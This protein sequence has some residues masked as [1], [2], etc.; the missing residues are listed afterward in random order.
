MRIQNN[1]LREGALLTLVDEEGRKG[2]GEIA[3]LPYRS[4]ETLEE[5]INQGR[6]LNV[7][8]TEWTKENWLEKLSSLSLLPSLS[9][10][11]ESA[12]LSIL[13]PIDEKKILSSAFFMGTKED[14]LMQ[15]QKAKKKGFSFAKLKVSTLSMQESLDII[16]ILRGDFRLRIDVNRSWQTKEC[17]DFFSHFPND[18][19]DYVEEPFA[20]PEDLPLFSHP[21]AIDESLEENRLSL[22]DLENIPMLKALVYKPTIQ[23]GISEALPLYTW[24]KQ[25]DLQFILGSS[26]ESKIGLTQIAHMASRLQINHPLGIGTPYAKL[27]LKEGGLL[28]T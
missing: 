10:G 27:D 8:D 21:F 2:Q 20:I 7:Y 19:F 25:R 5:C 17:L 4:K 13:W 18:A 26:F 15:A 6:K 16:Q 9:F 11:L 12:L 1:L 24:A 3:P 22:K 23:G 14:I 28:D